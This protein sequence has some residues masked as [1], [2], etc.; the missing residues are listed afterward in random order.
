MCKVTETV[1]YAR[2]SRKS[3]SIERQIRNILEVAPNAYIYQEA[4]TGTKVEGRKQFELMRKAA[5]EGKIKT[6]IFDSVSRMSR[7]AEIGFELYKEFYNEGI[8]L[9]FIKEPHINT[10]VYKEAAEKQI[11]TVTTGDNATDELMKAITDGINKYMMRLAEKQIIIAFEQAEKEVTDLHQR[12]VEGLQ[13]A[14]LVKGKT[15]GRPKGLK[16]II[17]KE[18][19][20]KEAII[21]YSKDFEGTLG[22]AEV[23]KL[24]GLARNTYYKYK[25]EIRE[26]L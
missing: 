19:P 26:G 5:K 1:G 3:Q 21:K 4:F 10:A 13:T 17:K 9:I 14:V 7:N 6:I 2:I 8:E 22:D 18:A 15:L 11:T 23:I 25:R 24:V 12:T 16:P 20:A